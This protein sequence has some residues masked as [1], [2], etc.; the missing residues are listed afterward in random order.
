MG[1][2]YRDYRDKDKNNDGVLTVD[3]LTISESVVPAEPVSA[4]Q[5]EEVLVDFE[6]WYALRE[7]A[8]P[9][10]H[11]KEIIKADF[12]ARKLGDKASI[13]DFDNA[14]KKYGITLG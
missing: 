1:K 5:P 8:I 3:E 4:P 10:H 11:H 9:A 12:K 6:E 2:K 14:L 13:R 7:G